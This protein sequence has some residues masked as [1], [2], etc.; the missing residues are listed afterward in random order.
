MAL[1]SICGFLLLALLLGLQLRLVFRIWRRMRWS[2]P[3]VH[4]VGAVMPERKASAPLLQM[5][6][7]DVATSA[8][9]D[10]ERNARPTKD[11]QP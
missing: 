9:K 10:T 2:H 11:G 6:A 5:C 1:V 7:P 3:S 8:G 4:A